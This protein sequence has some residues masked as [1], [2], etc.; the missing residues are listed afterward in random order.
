MRYRQIGD[1]GV[2]VS[3][4]G[5]GVWTVSA[6]WWGEYSDDDAAKLMHAAVERGVTFFDT[7]DTYGQGRGETVMKHAFPGSARDQIVIGAKFGYDWQSRN[8]NDAGHREAPHRFDLAFLEASLD[9]SL[10]RMGTDRIDFY[11]IHNPRMAMMLRDDIWTFVERAKAA[12]KVLS[13]GV[14]LGPAI[15]WEEEGRYAMEHL[16]VDGVQMIYNALE[17]DPGRAL[18]DVAV[19]TNKSLVVRVPHSSGMLEGKYTADTV[20]P[21]H[22]HRR[23]RPANWLPEGLEKI[24]QLEFLTQENG[25]T[26]A[27]AALRFVLHC[28]NVVSALPNI[29]NLEQIEEFCGASDV[30]D[31]TDAQSARINELY[32][33][34]YGMEF[35]APLNAVAAGAGGESLGA[36]R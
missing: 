11:Q 10:E 25:G 16:P 12:G 17:L 26:L 13:V 29:Y 23:H 33:T 18:I 19:A 9:A 1:T 27:Q 14:A 4:V 15:G 28:P 22:D 35:T 7:A 3:E 32:D 8:P 36:A 5:F 30:A 6:G 24:K 34:N 31:V 2:T 21:E 20:F